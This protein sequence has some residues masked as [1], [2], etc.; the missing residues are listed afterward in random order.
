MKWLL[1]IAALILI[2]ILANKPKSQSLAYPE[3]KK[4]VGT[5]DITVSVIQMA[6]QPQ[7]EIK[8]DTH[9]E[10]LVSEIDKVSKLTDDKGN[11]YSTSSWKGSASG[12]HHREG[13]LTFTDKLPRDIKKVTLT[14]SDPAVEFAWDL[15]KE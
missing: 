3:Q 4:T 14:L 12:G 13:T 11:I 1:L 8:L 6:Q 2:T 9:S 10:E 7:F 5:I 15:N